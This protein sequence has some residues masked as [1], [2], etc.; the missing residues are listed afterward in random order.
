MR[1][2]FYSFCFIVVL[3]S[4]HNFSMAQSTRKDSIAVSKEKLKAQELSKDSAVWLST[5]TSSIIQKKHSP[6]KATIL[7]LVCPGLGQIYNRQYWKTPIILGFG[8]FFGIMISSNNFDYKQAKRDYNIRLENEADNYVKATA[9]PSLYDA[10]DPKNLANAQNNIRTYN[11]FAL[12][13]TRDGYRRD[14]DFYIIMMGVVYA[15]NI[16]DATV[17]AHLREFKMSEK[18][19]MRIDPDIR[20]VNNAS[21]STGI[22]CNFVLK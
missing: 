13:S 18:L 10:Y 15:L 6:R 22:S 16:V 2:R 4:A 21:I 14:R 20:M 12:R 3:L 1:F 5:D 9:D 17:F 11:T 19:S 8:V 7:S